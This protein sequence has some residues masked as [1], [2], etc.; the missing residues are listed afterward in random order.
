M[1]TQE[2]AN[3]L[4]EMC[5]QGQNMEALAELYAENCVSHEMPGMPNE[6]TEGLAAIT[7]KSQQWYETVEEFHGGEVSDPMVAGNHFTCKMSFDITFKERG[8]S[9]MEELCLY[10]VADGKI[11]SEQFF[12]TMDDC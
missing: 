9:Q 8:R 2:V 7:T 6:R 3:R 11:V 10:E 12:Y 1:S 4:V 5:R